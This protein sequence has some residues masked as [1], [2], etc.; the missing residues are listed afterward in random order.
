MAMITLAGY[1]ASGKTTRAQ[2]LLAYL[3]RR[4]QD[5]STPPQF[6]RLK[7]VLINDES[8]GLAKSV[9]DDARVEKPARA[10][11]FSAVQRSLG[12]DTIVVVDAM[13]YIKG[14]RYQMYCAAREVQSRTCT[15][16][17]ATPPPKCKDWNA[18]RTGDSVYAETTLDNL[19]CRFEEPNG[20]ARWDAP[21]ITVACDDPALTARPEGAEEGVLGSEA[22]ERIW[23]AIT[24]GEVK[25]AN[26]AV[27]P[28]VTSS[29]SY[30]T[31]LE[32]TT[33]LLIR[34]L[35]SQQSLSPLMGTT[36]LLLPTSPRETRVQLEVN[37]PVTM[38]QLQR[39][40]RQFTTLNARAGR[41][42]GQEAIASMFAEYVQGQLR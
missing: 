1:P 6:A 25:P 39:L 36:T 14:S 5:P 23:Q 19:I 37:K 2:E 17:I 30:L 27:A 9:Y 29:T 13:N 15:L 33:S 32:S 42:F 34:T 10:S 18:T 22:A 7:P 35:L 21:L 16:F 28:I 31:L 26:V 38:P 11:L 4:L 40:K 20:A 24:E 8:I 3:D 12:K 41:E